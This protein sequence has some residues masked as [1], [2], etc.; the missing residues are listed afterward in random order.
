MILMTRF[1]LIPINVVDG[2]Y[3]TGSDFRMEEFESFAR[4]I[5]SELGIEPTVTPQEFLGSLINIFRNRCESV[6]LDDVFGHMSVIGNQS[7]K[8]GHFGYLLY[9]SSLPSKV[10]W[11]LWINYFHRLING[12]MTGMIADPNI[13]NSMHAESRHDSV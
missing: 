6:G 12:E 10:V 13:L 3:E 1:Y 8:L 9:N 5:Q 7:E 4:N 11:N 2:N